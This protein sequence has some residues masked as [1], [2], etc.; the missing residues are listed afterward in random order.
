MKFVTRPERAFPFRIHPIEFK[1]NRM[2]N[3]LS[4]RQA[5]GNE[6]RTSS[7]PVPSNNH[8]SVAPCLNRHSRMPE[9]TEIHTAFKSRRK[10]G[11]PRSFREQRVTHHNLINGDFVYQIRLV[12]PLRPLFPCR[13]LV[14]LLRFFRITADVS[15]SR[16]YRPLRIARKPSDVGIPV[17]RLKNVHGP[18]NAK[19]GSIQGQTMQ[20]SVVGKDQSQ[21]ACVLEDWTGYLTRTWT[22]RCIL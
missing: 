20:L 13:F 12:G 16:H 19:K 21:G 9:S 8:A 7:I 18:N 3:P 4:I 5:N 6:F 15:L 17:H 1:L 22:S 14:T 10:R 2:Q 11:L